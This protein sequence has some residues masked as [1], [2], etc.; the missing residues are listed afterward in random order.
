[1]F[2]GLTQFRLLS[3]PDAAADRI[4]SRSGRIGAAD[5]S[6]IPGNPAPSARWTGLP[7]WLLA[8]RAGSVLFGDLA[9]DA[10][11]ITAQEL[12]DAC[13]GIAAAQHGVRDQRKIAHVPHAAGQWRAAIQIAAGGDGG[14]PPHTAGAAPP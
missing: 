10:E 3:K 7:D 11:Q 12:L 2:S 14:F 1:M 9:E 5:L 6:S 4:R 8:R 13:L